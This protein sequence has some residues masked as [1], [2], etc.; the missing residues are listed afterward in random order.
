MGHVVWDHVV[1]VVYHMTGG[2]VFGAAVHHTSLRIPICQMLW[3]KV[4]GGVHG[5][6]GSDLGVVGGGAQVGVEGGRGGVAT[7]REMRWLGVGRGHH[8][9]I[10][11]GGPIG[12]GVVIIGGGGCRLGDGVA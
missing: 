1:G 6:R 8:S 2:V 12:S 7:R 11:I 5:G 3:L 10:D 4:Q 9:T